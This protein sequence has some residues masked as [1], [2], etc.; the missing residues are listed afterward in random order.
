M[1]HPRA[2]S[3]GSGNGLLGPERREHAAHELLV[4]RAMLAD[5]PLAGLSS[6]P[7]SQGKILVS[8]ALGNLKPAKP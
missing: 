8:K 4:S 3:S 7:G 1:H 2:E 6:R 5:L